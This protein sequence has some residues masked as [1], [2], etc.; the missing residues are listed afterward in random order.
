KDALF[1]A[2]AMTALPELSAQGISNIAW[3]L[4]KIGGEFLYLPEM[5]RVADV[6]LTKVVDFDSENIANV[7]LAFA[8]M[9]HSAPRLFTELSK[10][11][12]DI[13]YTFQPQELTKLLWA[14][15]YLY[16]ATQQ[17]NYLS[18][19]IVFTRIHIMFKK[20]RRFLATTILDPTKEYFADA[21]TMD[22]PFLK[23]LGNPLGYT[24]LLHRHHEANGWKVVTVSHEKVS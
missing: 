4:S 15:A 8:S 23:N 14:F 7:A 12:S 9:K 18:L 22:K 24:V 19:L 21:Y 11:A 1:V 10:R 20:V 16:E 13:L 17:R 3:A 2:M 6:G 5:D